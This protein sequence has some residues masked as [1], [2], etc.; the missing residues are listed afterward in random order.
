MATP[1]LL[2]ICL[3]ET[4]RQQYCK[5]VDKPLYWV[6]LKETFLLLLLEAICKRP[7][8]ERQILFHYFYGQFIGQDILFLK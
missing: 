3:G 2:N 4:Q 8:K 7:D 5:V 1:D 6:V